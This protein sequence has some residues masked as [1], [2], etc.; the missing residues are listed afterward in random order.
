MPGDLVL[1]TA[2]EVADMLRLNLQVVQ[3]KLKAGEIPAYRIGREWR[4]ERGQLMAWMERHTN[5]RERPLTDRWFDS[6]GR[7]TSLPTQAAKAHAVLRRVAEVFE[8]DRAYTDE[9]TNAI[10][11]AVFDD[12]VRLRRELVG[13]GLLV[14]R[15]GL[16][17]RR[18]EAD[19]AP[20]EPEA[21]RRR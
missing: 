2:S 1:Y 21:R 20:R 9:D 10:L 11:G 19:S 4:I 18:G 15:D 5:Q 12:V 6:E 13:A 14:C 7:L 3:R 8:P 17:R 16:H